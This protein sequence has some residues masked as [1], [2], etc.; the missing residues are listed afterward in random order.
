MLFNNNFPV[1][2]V[3]GTTYINQAYR[4]AVIY[5]CRFMTNSEL[6]MAVYVLEEQ[7]ER[8]TSSAVSPVLGPNLDVGHWQR[9]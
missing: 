9:R 4:G 1:Q 8:H 6:I 5:P 7:E 2:Q 3:N